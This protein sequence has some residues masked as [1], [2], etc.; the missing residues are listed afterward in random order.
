[1]RAYIKIRAFEADLPKHG[2]VVLKFWLLINSALG[3]I[4]GKQVGIFGLCWVAIKLKI[5]RLP[6]GMSWGIP[7]TARQL[8][9]VLVLP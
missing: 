9:M 5:A 2:I 4:F 1:M 7:Y 8:C 6:M 3:L